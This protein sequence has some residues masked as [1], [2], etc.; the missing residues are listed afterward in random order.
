MMFATIVVT[1][2][3]D[4]MVMTGPGLFPNVVDKE[5]IQRE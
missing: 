5:I 1:L 4:S 2:P 3:P